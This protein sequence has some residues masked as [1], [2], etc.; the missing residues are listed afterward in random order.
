VLKAMGTSTRVLFADM[1]VQGLML[2]LIACIVGAFVELGLEPLI[3]L[4]IEVPT[5]AYLEVFV[6]GVVVGLVAA[7]VGLRRAVHI[8]P[9]LAF[10]R[11]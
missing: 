3:P 4:Q 5:A 6:V 11:Q 10:G 8:D 2:A 1:A 7:S 9:A